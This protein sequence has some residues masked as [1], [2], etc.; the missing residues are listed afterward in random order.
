MRL[1]WEIMRTESRPL[2]AAPELGPRGEGWVVGQVALFLL[3]LVVPQVRGAWPQALSTAARFAGL[4]VAVLGAVTFF[5]GLRSLG[6]SL[7]ALPR[8]KPDGA[9]VD[10]GVYEQVR[11]PVYAGLILLLLGLGL[12]RGNVARVALALA[13]SCF[14]DRKAALEE[15]LLAVALPRLSALSRTR[16]MAS[17]PRCTVPPDTILGF[18][19]CGPPSALFVGLFLQH[20]TT[21]RRLAQAEIGM[22]CPS[23]GTENLADSDFRRPRTAGLK[24]WLTCCTCSARNRLPGASP[25]SLPATPRRIRNAN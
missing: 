15:R 13:G 24:A 25:T 4:V 7:T 23:C 20:W 2:M 14:F 22:N 10:D 17:H 11:H 3:W 9:F 21:V 18:L 1:H 16:S 12:V 5:G 6:S 8:P 19:L